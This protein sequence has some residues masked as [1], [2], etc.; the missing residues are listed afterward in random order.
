MAFYARGYA[1]V[2]ANTD[3][4]AGVQAQVV[5]SMIEHGVSGLMISPAYGD[6]VATFDPIA[7]AGIATMQVLRQVDPRTTLFPFTSLDYTRGGRLAAAHLVAGGARRIAFVGG[8]M[9]VPITRERMS[10]YLAVMADE[11]L[12]PFALHGRPSRAFG[13]EAAQ[14][15]GRDHPEIEA[16]MCFND[17]VALGMISGMAELGRKVGPDF[18]LVG[19]D[20]IEECAQ[21]WPQLSSVRCDIA[22]FAR[23]AAGTMLDWL[24]RGARPEPEFRAGIE[25]IVRDSSLGA[26]A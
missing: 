21:V 19:F 20:D 7:R 3:E 9:G 24:E 4:D 11:G 10:G 2:I 8:L 16:A 22:G 23:H 13:R 12:A 5:G 17:V 15:L 18:R 25:L 6:A 26:A 14:R 1:T